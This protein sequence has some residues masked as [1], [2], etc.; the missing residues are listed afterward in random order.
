MDLT[1]VDLGLLADPIRCIEA[2]PAA[3][4]AARFFAELPAHFDKGLPP[5]QIFARTE[6]IRAVVSHWPT[7]PARP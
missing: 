2:E 6:F 1:L 4:D 5:E 3:L 7:G